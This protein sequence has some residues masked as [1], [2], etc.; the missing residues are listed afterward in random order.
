MVRGVRWLANTRTALDRAVWAAYDW[1]K[2]RRKTD[3]ETILGWLLV[4]NSEHS[5]SCD[6]KILFSRHRAQN[7]LFELN[8]R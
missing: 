3:D 4:L 5:I 7:Q 6:R 1:P 2:T 8:H